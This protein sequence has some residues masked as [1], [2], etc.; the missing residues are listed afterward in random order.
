MAVLAGAAA[1]I[2]LLCRLHDREADAD[3]I[4]ALSQAPVR[5]WFAL[6]TEGEDSAAG[7][8]LIESWLHD[9]PEA[10]ALAADFADLYLT[11][12]KRIAPNESYW[13]TEDHLERQEPMFSVRSW[14]AHYGLKAG[15]WRKR[16]DDH[17]VH[18]LEFVAT[19]LRDGRP[20]AVRDAGRFLDQHLLTWSRD[21]FAGQAQR[22]DTAFYA[23]LAL[24]SAAQMEAIRALIETVTG[25]PRAV[26]ARPAEVPATGPQ[27]NC[28]YVPG[29]APSW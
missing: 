1:D 5:D 24:I 17:L 14:Y 27:E 26:R 6:Q 12:A 28:G 2:D 16:A 21:W 18:Q 4:A 7:R 11:F 29:A 3:L 25:E 19:L 13:L 8:N 10:D 23:G 22:S 9:S 20:H 15:D